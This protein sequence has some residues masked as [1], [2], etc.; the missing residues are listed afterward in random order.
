MRAVQALHVAC[1]AISAVVQLAHIPQKSRKRAH[2][3]TADDRHLRASRSVALL[4]S[5][6]AAATNLKEQH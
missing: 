2:L 5:T 3:I 6:C 1:G 4:L